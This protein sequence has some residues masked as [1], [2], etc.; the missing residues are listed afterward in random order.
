MRGT[1]E[2]IVGA[3]FAGKTSE[4][5]KR[6]LWAEHQ[7]KKILVIKSKLDNRY[8]EKLISTHNNLSHQCFPME[9]WQKIRSMFIINKK[10]YDVLFLDEVQFMDAKETIDVVDEF[11]NDGIDIVCS[12]LD[13]DS[14]GKPW[15]T[16]SF[17]MGLADKVTKIYGFCNVCGLEATKT[18]RKIEGGSR[19]Q[20][21]SANIYEPRCLK[22]WE[23]R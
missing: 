11:L 20:V 22:H 4:L 3:M 23:P 19:T 9:N 8:S 12:G 13:Q 2:T 18:F 15:E 10:N 16:S 21:G 5:L 14:R 1:L 6:I 7:G 17:L